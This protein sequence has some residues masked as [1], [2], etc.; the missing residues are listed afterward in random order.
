M[1]S[2]IYLTYSFFYYV[3]SIYTCVNALL[4]TINSISMT[5][6]TAL[7]NYV[8]SIAIYLVVKR[9]ELNLSSVSIYLLLSD[10]CGFGHGLYLRFSNYSRKYNMTSLNQFPMEYIPVIICQ[11]CILFSSSW[12]KKVTRN[13]M[14][15]ISVDKQT[16]MWTIIIWK[17]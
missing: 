7:N 8:K 10:S 14:I 2:S 17:Q 5:T 11:A 9:K 4:L 1:R 16:I 6:H 15:S 3:Y 12:V 13:F